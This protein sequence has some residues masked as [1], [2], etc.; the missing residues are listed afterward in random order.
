MHDTGG[1]KK[2]LTLCMPLPAQAGH[3]HFHYWVIIKYK[4]DRG[5]PSGSD[6]KESAYSA[7]YL[8]SIPGLGRFPREGNGNP[9]QYSCLENSMDRGTWQGTVHG[10]EKSWT[11]LSKIMLREFLDLKLILA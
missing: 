7:G 5:F 1:K 3:A 10:I 9:L 8:G 6:S 4:S 11:R 2:N